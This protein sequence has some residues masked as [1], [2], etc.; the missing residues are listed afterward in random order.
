MRVVNA[1]AAA[2]HGTTAIAKPVRKPEPR[3][4]V[5]LIGVTQRAA[6]P[7][8]GRRLEGN[9]RRQQRRDETPRFLAGNYDLAGREIEREDIVVQRVRGA[10]VLVAESVHQ[11]EAR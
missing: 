8:R 1:P 11:S 4:E 9:G 10:V 2:H 7:E 3:P 6:G 5:V